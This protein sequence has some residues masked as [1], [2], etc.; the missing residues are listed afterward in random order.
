MK[1]FLDLGVW[2]YK[3]FLILLTI[4]LFGI[5][6]SSV[7]TRYF[8]NYSI[9]W[10]DELS[11]FVFIW[12][13]FLG[14]AFAYATNDHIGLDFVVERIKN[15]RAK[16]AVF[17]FGDVCVLAVL[18]VLTYYGYAVSMSATNLSPALYIPMTYVYGVSFV[19]GSMMVVMNLLKI[20]KDARAFTEVNK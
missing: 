2:L 4:A 11:R 3:W 16:V 5:V 8:L 20:A 19:S 9:P 6:G 1:K 17:L 7:F 18:V 10:A 13:S 12:V 15:K 14:A